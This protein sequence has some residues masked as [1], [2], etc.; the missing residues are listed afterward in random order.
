MHSRKRHAIQASLVILLFLGICT[1][2]SCWVE[3]MM[4]PEVLPGRFSPDQE[5]ITVI[6]PE[7]LVDADG[8]PGVAR[9]L[10]GEEQ[11]QKMVAFEPLTVQETFPDG[12]ASALG[13][14]PLCVTTASRPLE[15]RQRVVQVDGLPGPEAVRAALPMLA[16]LL[17]HLFASLVLLIP[18]ARLAAGLAERRPHMLRRA[19]LLLC[20]IA[21]V[22]GGLALILSKCD[23]PNQYLPPNNI[24]DMAFYFK[25]WKVWLS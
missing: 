1:M 19:L 21:A 8:T 12:S 4:L 16:L 15:N 24:F 6:P 10:E 13:D 3:E 14:V 22:F 20:C 9:L 11:G 17:V 5:G 7:A 18:V 2:L 25:N 23:I